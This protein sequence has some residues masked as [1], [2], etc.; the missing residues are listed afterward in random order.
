MTIGGLIVA[1]ILLIISRDEKRLAEIFCLARRLGHSRILFCCSVA[2]FSVPESF[3]R[4]IV[5]DLPANVQ[6]P[7]LD[8]REG[9]GVDR[10]IE[11]VLIG[12]EDS[13]GHKRNYFSSENGA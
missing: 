12:E 10:L 1:A 5:F 9:C 2:R 4:E 6:N 7:R 13:I 11:A 3:E 8:I